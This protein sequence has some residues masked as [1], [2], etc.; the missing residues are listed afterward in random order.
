MNKFKHYIKL[1]FNNDGF[2]NGSLVCQNSG[3]EDCETGA[4]EV[5]KDIQF[6]ALRTNKELELGEVEVSISL[7]S[8][9][10]WFDVVEQDNND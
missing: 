3:C 2:I 10:I 9:E 6:E 7:S 8:E 4:K 5:W 1:S